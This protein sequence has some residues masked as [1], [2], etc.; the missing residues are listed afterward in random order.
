LDNADGVKEQRAIILN[1]G[2]SL[3]V[4][5]SNRISYA[6]EELYR[7]KPDL[8]KDL[9][10]FSIFQ[11]GL[12]NSPVTLYHILPEHIIKEISAP[13]GSNDNLFDALMQAGTKYNS[14]LIG[15]LVSDVENKLKSSR[16]KYNN[17]VAD[18][19]V[20]KGIEICNK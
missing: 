10:I 15:Y 5:E 8:A 3:S 16:N 4:D 12:M 13:V 18:M 20:K 9:V 11:S 19:A 14:K 6:F 2:A 7:N 1:E 17:K